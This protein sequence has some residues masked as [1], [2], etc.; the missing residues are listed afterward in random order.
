MDLA[1]YNTIFF[2]VV[3][4]NNYSPIVSPAPQTLYTF[5]KDSYVLYSFNRPHKIM[6]N[7]FLSSPIL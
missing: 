2:E 3:L 4:N 5:F 7:A 1:D 6:K